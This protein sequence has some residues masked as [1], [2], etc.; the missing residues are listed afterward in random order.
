MMRLLHKQDPGLTFT[1][2]TVHNMAQHKTINSENIFE[3]QFKETTMRISSNINTIHLKTSGDSQPL[4]NKL[5]SLDETK[6]D[7]VKIQDSLE[8]TT[9]RIPHDFN[10]IET[11]A[12]VD[13]QP[14]DNK[15]STIIE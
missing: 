14:L 8:E 6:T 9:M 10:T 2:P 5:F 3:T 12:P 4:N 15:L 7:L 1:N 13:S 11:K